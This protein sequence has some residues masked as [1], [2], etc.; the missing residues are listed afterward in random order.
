MIESP[1]SASFLNTITPKISANSRLPKSLQKKER[2]YGVTLD[3]EKLDA[4]IGHNPRSSADFALKNYGKKP[5]DLYGF[6]ELYKEGV[7]F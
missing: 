2:I 4:K 1:S 5:E 7:L 6:N 3:T